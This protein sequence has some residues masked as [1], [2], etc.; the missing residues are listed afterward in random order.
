[1]NDK[2]CGAIVILRSLFNGGIATE[3]RMVIYF[4][5]LVVD[6]M[7][8]VSS[9]H[10]SHSRFAIALIIQNLVSTVC[11]LMGFS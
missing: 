9:S 8:S 11:L 3:P 6:L 2:L 7:K 1:M 5:F 10:S 4:S